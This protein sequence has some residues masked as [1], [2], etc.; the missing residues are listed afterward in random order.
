MTTIP[1][2]TLRVPKTTV[3][4][5][6]AGSAAVELVL[7]TPLLVVLLLFVVLCGRLASA[8]LDLDAAAHAAA[9][10]AS[11][12]RTVP[13]ATTDARRTALDTLAARQVT[14]TEPTV[15]VDT[16][17]LRPGGVVTVTVACVV[18]LRE[19][20]LLAVPGSRAVSGTATSPVDVFRGG[21]A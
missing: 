11:I 17:G 4:G 15:T 2:L 3:R 16:A 10:A 7:L 1:T 18:P 8:K 9:R 14:C 13:A 12:A 20:A 19:L 21:P 6:D 5:S